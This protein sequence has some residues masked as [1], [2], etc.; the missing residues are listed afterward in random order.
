MVTPS[1]Q[2]VPPI[3]EVSMESE[4]FIIRTMRPSDATDRFSVWFDA[5]DV[6]DA[7]NLPPQKRTKANME[8]YI[9][10]F[11]QR[12]DLLLA[13][14]AKASGVL[15]GMLSLYIDWASGRFIANMIVGEPDYR[16]KGATME[17]TP[18]FREYFFKTC[19]LK[20][21]TATALAHNAPI[22]AYLDNTG[23]TLDRI[24]K[25]EVRSTSG[26][27]PIDL[28]HYSLTAEAWFKWLAE[29]GG[30]RRKSS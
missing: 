21:M 13:I 11:D 8:T 12:R 1:P 15:V 14:I 5:P 22:R 27:A 20:V 24:V 16:H 19:G 10:S 2:A 18:P 17:I 26:G 7:L 29:N 25:G 28:C 6:R 3:R 23:W 4:N 9:R 30:P